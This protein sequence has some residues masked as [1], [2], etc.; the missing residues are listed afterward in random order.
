[1]SA[2]LHACR[3]VELVEPR[4]GRVDHDRAAERRAVLHGH[5][6]HTAAAGREGHLV[7]GR[8]RVRVRVRVR[9]RVR[10]RVRII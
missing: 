8:V 10:V 4:A 7:R 1:M 2:E 3:L 5:A 9:A 6:G